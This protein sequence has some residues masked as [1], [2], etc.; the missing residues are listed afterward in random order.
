MKV[1]GIVVEYNPFHNGHLYHVQKTKEITGAD[2]VVAVMSGN[3]LQRGEFALLSK[4]LRTKMAL[5]N[6]VDLVIELPYAYSTQHAEVFASGSVSLL[7]HIGVDSICF[8]SE[9]GEIDMFKHCLEQ[10][11]QNNEDWKIALHNSLNEGNSYAKSLSIASET[12]STLPKE[13]LSSPNNI[14]GLSY[15]KALAHLK[16]KIEVHTIGRTKAGYHDTKFVDQTIASAT[17]IRRA[18]FEKTAEL[19]TIKQYIPESTYEILTQYINK[20]GHFHQWEDYFSLLRYEIIRSTPEDLRMIYEVEEGL[21]YRLKKYIHESSSFKE[22]MSKIKSKRYTWTRL[23]RMLLHIA[24]NAKKDIMREASAKRPD[25]IRPLGFTK[26]GQEILKNGKENWEVPVVY[27]LQR[28][29]STIA[30]LQTRVD[31]I[32]TIPFPLENNHELLKNEQTSAPIIL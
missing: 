8:G 2:A 5:E 32:Y 7:E 3:F 30:S 21:E 11:K 23:Q 16:S 14:L 24:T 15:M 27:N 4:W 9:Y 29:D 17:A 18:L 6:G 20:E 25:F 13:F 12:I 22:F 19:P 31:Q 1:A 26:K 28:C 10:M